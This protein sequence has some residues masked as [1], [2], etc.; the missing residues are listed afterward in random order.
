MDKFTIH[1]T[2]T[3]TNDDG[4]A[5]VIDKTET[6][7]FL[8]A[9]CGTT[10]DIEGGKQINGISHTLGM[11][12]VNDLT[13]TMYRLMLTFENPMKLSVAM[14]NAYSIY[15]KERSLSVRAEAEP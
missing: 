9:I 13:E 15:A 7:E 6:G 12:G 14:L 8:F 4:T 11:W 1:I 3:S 5:D 10:E 2:G